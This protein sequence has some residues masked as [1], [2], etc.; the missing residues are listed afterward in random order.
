MDFTMP[1][2][3]RRAFVALAFATA[4]ALTASGCAESSTPATSPGATESSPSMGSTEPTQE[5]SADSAEDPGST[6][7]AGLE[8]L[9]SA[10]EDTVGGVQGYVVDGTMLRIDFDPAVIS[11][12]ELPSACSMVEQLANSLT[13][14][15]GSTAQVVLGEETL[16]CS[17]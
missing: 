8:S 17:L 10:L 6:L 2:G 9:G 11:E 5:S 1:A 15:E 12:N 3:R 7:S 4:A 16:D 13:L 14:P